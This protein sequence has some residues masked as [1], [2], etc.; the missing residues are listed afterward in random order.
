MTKSKR[1]PPKL[2]LQCRGTFTRLKQTLLEPRQIA[3]P[4]KIATHRR[5]QVQAHREDSTQ[6]D[7]CS[8]AI[9]VLDTAH[10]SEAASGGYTLWAINLLNEDERE[11]A[12][13]F[14]QE[15][16]IV[17]I[18]VTKGAERPT[19]IKVG[20]TPRIG[21]KDGLIYNVGTSSLSARVVDK[22]RF[23]LETVTSWIEL[24]MGEHTCC[25]V[26][27]T[28]NMT[29]LKVIDCYSKQVVKHQTGQKYITLSYVWGKNQESQ[30][31]HMVA[32]D[33][34]EECPNT[35]ADAI[36]V[37]KML[38]YRFLWVDRYCIN[39]SDLL[40]RF[41]QID[42]MDAIYENADL[43]IVAGA[44]KDDRYGLP[45]T[46]T[47]R[48][49][50]RTPQPSAQLG[51]LM[52][53]STLP[54]IVWHL[55]SSKWATR[56]WTYQEAM[57]SRRCLVFFPDQVWFLCRKFCRSEALPSIPLLASGERN[58]LSVFHNFFGD[59]TQAPHRGSGAY[60]TEEL[61]LHIEMYS[62]RHLT[63]TLDALNAFKGILNRSSIPQFWGVPMLATL[64]PVYATCSA[65]QDVLELP[66]LPQSTSRFNLGLL[67]GLLWDA[68]ERDEAV[69]EPAFPT[70]SW[71]S[72]SNTSIEYRHRKLWQQVTL[73]P[74]F[75]ALSCIDF[76]AKAPTDDSSYG[77]GVTLEGN[78]ARV[79]KLEQIDIL[80]PSTPYVAFKDPDAM[81]P[82]I[83][84]EPLHS[85]APS[86]VNEKSEQMPT[87]VMGQLR[88]DSRALLPKS[89]REGLSTAEA[90][91]NHE[92]RNGGISSWYVL[93]LIGLSRQGTEF[94]VECLVVEK[95]GK[96]TCKRIGTTTLIDESVFRRKER[97]V[98][99]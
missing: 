12:I 10:G 9:A 74:S 24:C 92:E 48:S 46:G 86:L 73:A 53:A 77:R 68:S 91:A 49:P 30:L 14:S 54:D 6:C 43:T 89:F 3:V 5:A 4:E 79:T 50:N 70:W 41:S 78:I 33:A 65:I 82:T 16:F 81:L 31:N 2:C 98:L 7:L 20:A 17:A 95:T 55:K 58:L 32:N 76:Q 57:L 94:G 15:K 84:V 51:D 21:R 36:E 8:I 29:R 40:E 60:S 34:L 25:R 71:L 47:A 59:S 93:G 85:P 66:D 39:Q 37:T 26:K 35:I 44:G 28:R 90:H 72:L 11:R 67:W 19:T 22:R 83:Y 23:H 27:T 18:S 42:Q 52:L 80:P 62:T 99:L 56:G 45:G 87:P 38:G 88:Y 63:Y 61:I 97:L 69:R 1:S 96:D 13:G 75:N 64:K